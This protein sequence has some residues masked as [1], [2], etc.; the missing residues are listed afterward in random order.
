[1]IKTVLMID[2][3][4][5]PMCEAHVNDAIREAFAVKKVTSSHQKG[6]TVIESEAALDESALLSAVTACGYR[7]TG[8][9]TETVAKKGFFSLF[10]K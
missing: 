4:M 6:E 7:V 10:G 3:M 8:V 5:C 1:M 9:R 2:G